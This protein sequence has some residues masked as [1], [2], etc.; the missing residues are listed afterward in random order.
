MKS[1]NLFAVSAT[2]VA[3]IAAPISASATTTLY[4]NMSVTTS[5]FFIASSPFYG[6]LYQS[7]STQGSPFSL[8]QFDVLLGAFT[9]SDGESWICP[10]E[11]QRY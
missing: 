8:S 4:D 7:F 11:R 5:G 9:P 6:P 10:C 1:T 2:I 3:A